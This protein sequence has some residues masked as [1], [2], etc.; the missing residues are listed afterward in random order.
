VLDLPGVIAHPQ[1]K[2]RNAMQRINVPGFGEVP[3]PKAPFHFSETPTEIP[4]ELS[5]LGQ[6]N[7]RVLGKYLGYSAQRVAELTA[8]GLLGE[9]QMLGERR[10]RDAC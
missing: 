9:A 8:S 5:M 3:L 7:E 2:A 10:K 4:P 1:M 6:D